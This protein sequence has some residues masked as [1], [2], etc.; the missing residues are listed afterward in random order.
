MASVLAGATDAVAF[1]LESGADVTIGEQDGYTPMHG[2][3]FQGRA[4]VA[5][6]LIDHGI[7]PSNMHKDGFTPIHRAGW[8]KEDRH[9][10]TVRIFLEA[11]VSVFEQSRDGQV[12]REMSSN[13][14]TIQLLKKWEKRVNDGSDL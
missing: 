2:A 11:G 1:L 9:T 7:D 14:A 6:L 4:D 3:G 10:D 5:K 8:G 12:A 13:T